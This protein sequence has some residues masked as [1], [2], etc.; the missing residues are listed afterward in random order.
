MDSDGV[1]ILHSGHT[2]AVACAVPHNLIFKLLPAGDTFFNSYLMQ[3]RDGKH[4][5]GRP[6]KLLFCIAKFID[7]AAE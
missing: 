2:D 5:F 3:R 6:F 4:R 7:S 1:E